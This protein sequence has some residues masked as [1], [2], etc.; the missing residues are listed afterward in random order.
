[1]NFAFGSLVRVIFPAADFMRGLLFRAQ[2]KFLRLRFKTLYTNLVRIFRGNDSQT[3]SR[4]F[5]V[6]SFLFLLRRRKVGAYA[7]V[8]FSSH[9]DGFR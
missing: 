5:L 1:M 8:V 2:Q 3:S 4:T 9:A 6:G 7:L